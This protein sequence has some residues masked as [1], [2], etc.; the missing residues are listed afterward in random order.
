[1]SVYDTVELSNIVDNLPHPSSFLLDTGFPLTQTSESEEIAFDVRDG[2]RKIA[3][4]VSPLVAGKIIES[5]G[6]RTEKFKPAYLKPKSVLDSERP[7]KRAIGETIGGALAP[8]QRLEL[9]LQDQIAEHLDLINRRLEVMASEVLRL[10]RVTVTGEMYPTKVVDFGRHADHTVTLLTT[11][12]WSAT[13]TADPAGDLASWSLT[14]LKRSGQA[15]TVVIM[16]IDAWEAFIQNPTVTARLDVRNLNAG[17]LTT[18]TPATVG[19]SYMGTLN[20]RAIFVYA[21]WYVD[22]ADGEEKPILPSGTVL[23]LAP[24]LQG[25]RAFGAIRDHAAGYQAVPYFSKSWTDEDPSVRYLLTQSAPLLIPTVPNASIGAR[26][27]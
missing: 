20:G 17:T 4:F 16:D 13:S 5:Q 21:D 19:A 1:M 11:S 23:L 8:A 24:R 14:M 22:P 6:F 15:P 26:V 9:I 7:L 10:G 3:P 25:V 12:K 18:G 27:L 2:T